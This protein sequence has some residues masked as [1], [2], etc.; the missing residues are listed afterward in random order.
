MQK[1]VSPQQYI[2][3]INKLVE[4]NNQLILQLNNAT[5][6]NA[7]Y[8]DIL[9]KTNQ[10][11]SLWTNPY[12]VAV[13]ILSVVIGLLALAVAYHIFIAQRDNKKLFKEQVD[14]AVKTIKDNALSEFQEEI[15]IKTEEMNKASGKNKE[16]LKKEI[17]K[18]TKKSKDLETQI[19]LNS[20]DYGKYMKEEDFLCFDC[21]QKATPFRLFSTTERYSLAT[22]GYSNIFNMKQNKCIRCGHPI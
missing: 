12:G 3:T 21:R 7:I 22:N 19:Q 5:K 17:D 4:Q 13:G 14:L 8:A 2:D 11:L 20:L 6:T 10:Q 16:D 18:I 1:V 9:E 15:K